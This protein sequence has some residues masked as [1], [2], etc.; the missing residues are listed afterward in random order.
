M[1]LAR[2]KATRSAFTLV[3]LLVVIT[4]IGCH[5]WTADG[6]ALCGV[7]T[8]K[9]LR[10]GQR[11]LPGWMSLESYKAKY[12]VILQTCPTSPTARSPTVGSPSSMPLLIR[13]IPARIA[14]DCRFPKP[15]AHQIAMSIDQAE[16]LVLFWPTSRDPRVPSVL[17]RRWRLPGSPPMFGPIPPTI[18]KC[19]TSSPLALSKTADLDGFPEFIQKERQRCAAAFTLMHGV[20]PK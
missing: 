17:P 11:N 1:S 8:R 18:S 12:G 5:R 15:A 6:G 2:Q 9:R 7:W 13:P 4:I 20:T 10:P 19:S 3:E 14:R 16:A